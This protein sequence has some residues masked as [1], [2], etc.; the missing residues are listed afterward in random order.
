MAAVGEYWSALSGV[1]GTKIDAR[2]DLD[3]SSTGTSVHL[4]ATGLNPIGA[5]LH[6]F[7][8]G[9]I[10]NPFFQE[11]PEPGDRSRPVDIRCGR[12]PLL[13]WARLQTERRFLLSFEIGGTPTTPKE[14]TPITTEVGSFRSGPDIAL[15]PAGG[16]GLLYF[17]AFDTAGMLAVHY[18]VM[19]SGGASRADP[20]RLSAPVGTFAFS[21]TICTENGGYGVSSVNLV[22]AAGGQLWYSRTSSIT[23]AFSSWTPIA[24]APASSPD[25]FVTG[26]QSV[27]HVV[28]LTAAGTLREVNGNGTAWTV[29]D[30]GSPR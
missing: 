3:C 1:D 12:H 16:S 4:V 13:T 15:Q 14:F 2:S 27:V 17:A 29:T 25:C 21:P 24:D 30:L 6:T 23:A 11:F 7:G 5:F 22:A 18:N 28:T 26:A 10:Y 8:T 19:N 20:V 9:T